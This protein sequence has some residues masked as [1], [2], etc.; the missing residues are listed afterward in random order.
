[1]YTQILAG[2]MLI[3]FGLSTLM[4]GS[5]GLNA[6][7]FGAG[8]AGTMAVSGAGMI[9]SGVGLLLG[10]VAAGLPALGALAAGNVVWVRQRRRSLGRLPRVGELGG[11]A[12]LVGAVVLLIVLD[13]R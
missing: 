4:R 5:D 1:M 9:L 12:V 11:R 10:I 7:K 13:W 2:L 3:P 6:G 8:E